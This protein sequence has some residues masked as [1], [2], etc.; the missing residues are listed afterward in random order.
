MER[1]ID[2]RRF[3]RYELPGGWIVLAGKTDA[4]NEYLSL[5]F[6]HP[7]DHWFHASGCPGSHVLLLQQE[8][9][10][11][12]RD[13]V[14]GAAAVAA[15]HSKARKAKKVP[16]SVCLAGDVSKQRG[17]PRGQVTIR[18]ERVIKVTPALPDEPESAS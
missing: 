11:A 15:W 16:V 13:A 3:R 6:A 12:D 18:R 14:R 4:D 17:S 2:T 7:Q 8:G 9:M 5:R 1:D 10:E